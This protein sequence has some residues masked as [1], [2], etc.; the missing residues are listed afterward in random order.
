MKKET[1]YLVVS[2]VKY[3]GK[4][5]FFVSRTEDTRQD[6]RRYAAWLSTSDPKTTTGWKAGTCTYQ[7]IKVVRVVI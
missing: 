2:K 4:P 3:V 1:I 5:A 7:K 6:A